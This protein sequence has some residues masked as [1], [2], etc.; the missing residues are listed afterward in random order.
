MKSC[1]DTIKYFPRAKKAHDVEYKDII[2][3]I[4]SYYS[5]YYKLLVEYFFLP[6]LTLSLLLFIH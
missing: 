2:V 6:F 1:W 4:I 5:Y 3:I